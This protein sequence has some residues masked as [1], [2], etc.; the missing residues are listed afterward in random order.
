MQHMRQRV[1]ASVTFR[2][3]VKSLS[4]TEICFHG[5]VESYNV[6][7]ASGGSS[8]GLRCDFFLSP[9]FS[10]SSPKTSRLNFNK[11]IMSSDLWFD[12]FWSFFFYH[13]L[14]SFWCFLN[15]FFQFYFLAFYSIWFFNPIWSLYF[16]F[17][18]FC[19]LYFSWLLFICKFIP[20]NFIALFLNPIWSVSFFFN[21]LFGLHCLGF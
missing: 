3:R 7:R 9:L 5:C 13:C 20:S 16:W 10:F 18:Y 12:W 21:T 2:W 6:A 19:V 17:L 4:V 14:F 8:V 11:T 1:M 15:F